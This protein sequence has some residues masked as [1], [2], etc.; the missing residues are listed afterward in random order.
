MLDVQP[1]SYIDALEAAFAKIEQNAIV[2]SWK[3]SF[4][5]GR[6]DFDIDDFVQIP[7]H[8]CFRDHR[9]Q[10]YS[11]RSTTLERIW[12]I[13]GQTGWYYATWLWKI[14]GYLD[15]LV[16]GVGLRRGRRHPHEINVGDAV[17]FWRVIYADKNEGR[18]LL[19]AEMRLPGDAWLE[20]DIEGDQLH[21]KA[22]FRPR[23]VWGR[24]YWYM[25]LP[26]HGLIFS[27]MLRAIT[28]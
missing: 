18:L 1:M 7:T 5:S 14:R 21:Q 12:S 19:Y 17:D 6:Y 25:V 22:T 4:I 11:N 10:P 15:K 28:R 24:V 13:G 16:G 26:F 2:S 8:G 27:G 20:F 3:D 9:R 23:G